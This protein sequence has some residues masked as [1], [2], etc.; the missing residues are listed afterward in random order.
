MQIT[1]EFGLC[2]A[3]EAAAKA[4]SEDYDKVGWRSVTALISPPRVN[5]LRRRHDDMITD[6]VMNLIHSIHGSAIH[7]ILH[8]AGTE[9]MKQVIS[10]ERFIVVVAGKEIS[11][12]PDWIEPF[13]DG[14]WH[15]RDFKT[16]KAYAVIYGKDEAVQQ[17]NAYRYLCGKL[18]IEITQMTIEALIKDWDYMEA[19]RDKRYP[20]SRVV[21]LAIPMWAE[22]SIEDFLMKRIAAHSEAEA[23]PDDQLP[24]C[25]DEERWATA[26]VYAVVSRKTKKA[27]PRCA[28]FA[29]LADAEAAKGSR[30]DC[31]VQFR[32]GISKRCEGAGDWAG[33]PCRPWC[34]QYRDHILPAKQASVEL[35]KE[36]ASTTK[37]ESDEAA[38]T[39]A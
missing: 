31:F 22:T 9:L 33:C 32:P 7:Y 17:M 26:D 37:E 27:L 16:W 38:Q 20:Q 21:P 39:E 4:F 10:E 11:F 25:T 12:K 30:S 18:G 36:F 5:E 6:D 29:T 13:P 28:K 3:W 15:L 8:R 24:F 19:A 35:A 14:T 23:L 1:N 34:N 2:S